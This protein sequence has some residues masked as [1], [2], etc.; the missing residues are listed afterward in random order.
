VVALFADLQ[1][2]YERLMAEGAV[3]ADATDE[4]GH[5]K[6]QVRDAENIVTSLQ[7]K[8]DAS[9]LEAAELADSPNRLLQSS[10][11]TL[12]KAQRD[13]T[14]YK[15]TITHLKADLKALASD[16]KQLRAKY[17][18]DIQQWSDQVAKCV[19]HGRNSAA[20]IDTQRRTIDLLRSFIVEMH[21]KLLG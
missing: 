18:D 17:H 1:A 21:E 12:D 13:E 16:A 2:E 3:K 7:E 15:A 8:Y 20:T 4:L 19:A 14:T 10:S 9:K 5:L 11:I 6:Q